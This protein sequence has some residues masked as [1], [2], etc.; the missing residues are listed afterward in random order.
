MTTFYKIQS[1]KTGLFSTG[2]QDPKWSKIGKVW[3]IKGHLSSHF[4]GLTK[5]G[6]RT[7]RDH[8]AKVVECTVTVLSE[9]STEDFVQAAA[10]RASDR[11]AAE[12][13]YIKEREEARERAEYERLHAKFGNKS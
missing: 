4:T 13:R 1:K 11:K 10:Q 5:D 8:D 12:Q 6:R 3:P 7:Y 9:Q 2:G